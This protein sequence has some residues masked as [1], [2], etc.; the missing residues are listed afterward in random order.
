MLAHAERYCTSQDERLTPIRRDLLRVLSSAEAPLGAYDI[1]GR[2][3]ELRQR[4]T[5]PVA[6]YRGLEFL[7]RVGLVTRLESQNAFVLCAHPDRPHDCVFL[8]CGTCGEVKEILDDR[9]SD[10]LEQR[11][12]E[13]GFATK[14]RVIEIHGMCKSCRTD[15]AGAREASR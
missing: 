6:A 12:K 5:T 3:S 11:A 4:R 2:L 15:E 9:L 1:A 10:L 8:L 14:R 7:S 13:A